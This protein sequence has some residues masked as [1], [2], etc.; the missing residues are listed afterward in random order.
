[1]GRLGAKVEIPAEIRAVCANQRSHGSVRG[2]SG[3]WYPYRDLLICVLAVA[4]CAQLVRAAGQ[5]VA[6][7]SNT[8][9]PQPAPGKSDSQPSDYDSWI[10]GYRKAPLCGALGDNHP[11]QFSITVVEGDDLKLDEKTAS[12]LGDNYRTFRYGYAISTKGTISFFRYTS[13]AIQG[14]GPGALPVEDFKK[15]QPLIASLPDDHSHLP[16]PGHRLVLQV[17]KGTRVLARVYD[18]ANMPDSVLEILRLAGTDIKPLVMDFPPEKKWTQGEFGEAGIPPD[19]I[20]IGT[21]KDILTLAVSPDRSLIVR[22]ALWYN[23][24]TQILDSKTLTVVY[25]VNE[26]Q[27][28]PR[29]IYISHAWFTPDGRF[30]LL[31]SNLPA[32]RIYDTKT[33]LQLDTL[34]GMPSGGVAYYPSLDWGHGLVVSPAGAVDLWDATAHSKLAR[35]DLNGEIQSVSFSPDNSLVAVTSVRQ[36]K[37]QSSTFH[38]RIWETQSGKFVHELM[39]LEHVAH[40][41]IGDPLWWANGKYLLAPVREDHLAGSYVVGIWNIQSGR[42]RGGLSGCEYAS[43]PVTTLLQGQR[44]FKRC[45]DGT[46]FTWD[47]AAVIDKI[48]EFENTLTQLLTHVATA[49]SL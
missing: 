27:F 4:S 34:P 11:I 21:P 24:R 37:D 14:S 46:L 25:E 38:L 8:E 9:S 39:P 30:L 18:R 16:P 32:I 7:Q 19:A 43:E 2:V 15:L 17:A 36:N 10:R 47:V 1:V 41:G 49:P 29:V 26:A 42:Y 6:G 44:L 20:G 31:L 12:I 23:P 3:N 48:T 22:Q 40:D 45:P 33:W 35:L 28:G 13:S 5:G